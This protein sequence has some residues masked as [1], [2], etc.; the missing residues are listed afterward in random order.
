MAKKQTE[1]PNDKARRVMDGVAVWASFYR[2]N[3]HRFAKD[4][5]SIDLKIFQAICST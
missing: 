2:A 1:I 3:P 5:L 4:D